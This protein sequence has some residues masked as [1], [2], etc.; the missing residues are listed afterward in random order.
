MPN[1]QRSADADASSTKPHLFN[2]TQNISKSLI[3]IEPLKALAA[4]SG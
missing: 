2:K 3:F 4:A 1:E